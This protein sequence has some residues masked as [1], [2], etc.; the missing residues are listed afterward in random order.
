[1][2][3]DHQS[4][5]KIV[6]VWHAFSS[7][8]TLKTFYCCSGRGS[9]PLRGSSP[10]SFTRLGWR[11]ANRLPESWWP[12]SCISRTRKEPHREELAAAKFG[13]WAPPSSFQWGMGDGVEVWPSRWGW[14]ISL[15]IWDV[16]PLAI[17]MS[18]LRFVYSF[19]FRKKEGDVYLPTNDATN[20]TW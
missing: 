18:V 12:N 14:W 6:S 17:L 2:L 11:R 1:M 10:S 16:E 9:V 4:K 13:N 19:F 5:M 20:P 15:W 3:Y 8:A 7:M